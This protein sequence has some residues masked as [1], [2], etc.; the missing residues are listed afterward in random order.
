[1]CMQSV[2]SI[3]GRTLQ[4]FDDD[5]IIPTFGFGDTITRDLSCFPFT[6]NRGCNGFDEV[7]RRYNELTPNLL[8]SGPTNFAPVIY[9]AIRTVQRER[10]YHI[11]VIIADGQVTKETETRAAI[12][13]ASKWPICMHCIYVFIFMVLFINNL[14]SV[15]I[16]MVGVGDGPWVSNYIIDK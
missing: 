16:I 7:L 6:T 5:N 10:G 8:L 4:P 12:V 9:E 14:I 11:L 3:V 1:M 15:A 2:I 13:E